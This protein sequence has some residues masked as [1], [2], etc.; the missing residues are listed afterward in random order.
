MMTLTN[1]PPDTTSHVCTPPEAEAVVKAT[2]PLSAS[3][4]LFPV[5]CVV[6]AGRVLQNSLCRH[7]GCG[8]CQRALGWRAGEPGCGLILP[9]DLEQVT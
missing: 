5:G 2:K 4:L 6:V 7:R 9:S 3:L 8:E 1:P